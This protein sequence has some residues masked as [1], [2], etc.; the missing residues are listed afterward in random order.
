MRITSIIYSFLLL[1]ILFS[2]QSTSSEKC[3]FERKNENNYERISLNF[4]DNNVIL[5]TYFSIA[6]KADTIQ[7]TIKGKLDSDGTI[8]FETETEN[9]TFE[10]FGKVEKAK[11]IL[12]TLQMF[13]PDSSKSQYKI[14]DKTNKVSADKIYKKVNC[15]SE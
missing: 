7:A 8:L 1:S 12:H 13:Q 11:L 2:C 4:L 6:K 14:L 15:S 10:Y 3:C 9:E 5:G